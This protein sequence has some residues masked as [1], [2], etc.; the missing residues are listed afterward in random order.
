MR[1]VVKT[2][3][4]ELIEYV[5][6]DCK[7]GVYRMTDTH[8]EDNSEWRDEASIFTWPTLYEMKCSNCGKT[9]KI[10]KPYP[11]L[12]Y[13]LNDFVLNKHSNSKIE[14]LR[15]LLRRLFCRERVE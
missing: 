4:A 8:P 14:A 1:K 12:R 6:T 13:R 3:R 10:A 5:C 9:G 7:T 11:V 15:R 2:V